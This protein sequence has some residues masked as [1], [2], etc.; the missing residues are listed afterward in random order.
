VNQTRSTAPQNSTLKITA[1]ISPTEVIVNGIKVITQETI[2]ISYPYS[3]LNS[4]G[5]TA[6]TSFNDLSIFP[7]DVTDVF[8]L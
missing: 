6:C 5:I 8:V 4:A 3:A 7:L 2:H 1:D